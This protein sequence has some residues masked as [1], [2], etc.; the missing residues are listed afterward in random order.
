MNPIT[1]F[2]TWL[3]EESEISSHRIPTAC[4]FS[5][6]GLD[7]FPNARFVSF[8][9]VVDQKFVLT[10][11]VSSRKGQELQKNPKAA[12]T[13]WWPNIE[14][15]VR[16]QG[17]VVLLSEELADQ[18][19]EERN[20]PSK[21]ISMISDQG[22]PIDSIEGLTQTLNDFDGDVTPGRPETWGGFVIDPV[23][24]ELLEFQESRLHFRRLFTKSSEG[25]NMSILQP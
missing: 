15:Q 11:P 10:G 23:R 18:Y 21:I 14:K 24:I 20:R 25:W 6:I 5:T 9:D 13:F 4:C 16:V 12:I 2:Q 3:K 19:F 1:T 17:T 8:K 7:G 22:S